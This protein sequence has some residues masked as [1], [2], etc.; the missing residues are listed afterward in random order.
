M[1][2]IM[3][4]RND[5]IEGSLVYGTNKNIG[6]DDLYEIQNSNYSITK[7]LQELDLSTEDKLIDKSRKFLKTFDLKSVDFKYKKKEKFMTKK[8]KVVVLAVKRRKK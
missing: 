5:F 4:C 3:L 6:E 7:Y 1:F 2:E 8:E